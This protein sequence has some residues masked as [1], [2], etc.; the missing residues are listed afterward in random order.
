MKPNLGKQRREKKGLKVITKQLFGLKIGRG[1]NQRDFKRGA[2]CALAIAG[3][4]SGRCWEDRGIHNL[5]AVCRLHSRGGDWSTR[6]RS[7]SN[8]REA[9]KLFSEV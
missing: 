8:V 2:V 7:R 5:C 6:R 1:A 9:V 4:G 3:G